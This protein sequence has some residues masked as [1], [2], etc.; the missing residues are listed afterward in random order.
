MTLPQEAPDPFNY[1]RQPLIP[2]RGEAA[3]HGRRGAEVSQT[4]L[5][6]WNGADGS[7]THGDAD[8]YEQLGLP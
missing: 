1:S 5:W 8:I 7:M 4:L 6:A 2:A 3:S